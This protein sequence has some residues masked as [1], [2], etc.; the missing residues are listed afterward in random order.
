MNKDRQPVV[1]LAPDKFKG[2]LDAFDVCDALAGGLLDVLPGAHVIRRP[3][4]DGG[5]GSLKVLARPGMQMISITVYDPLMRPIQAVYGMD[6]TRAF[7]EMSAAAGL[8]L[9]APEERNPLQTTT[10]GVGQMIADALHRGARDIYIMAGGSA[11][12]DAGMGMAA[13][14]GY[15]FTDSGARELPP[16]GAS[17]NKVHA[18]VPPEVKPWEKGRFFILADVRN[19]LY[20]PRGAAFEYAAQKGAD[21][22]AMQILDAG[23]RHWAAVVKDQLQTDVSTLSGGGAAG[24]LGAGAVAFL[25]ASIVSGARMIAALLGVEPLVARTD[26]LVSGE[27]RV[28]RQT[29]E[30]KVVSE[31]ARLARLHHKP[32]ALVCGQLE[33]DADTCRDVLDARLCLSLVNGQVS[34]ERALKQ[35]RALLVEKGRILG[36]HI[37]RAR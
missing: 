16:I 9:L 30:G 17:L 33:L 15:R 1:L 13:A 34:R 26:W 27:G 36:Q 35:A 2:S 5:E 18:I 23:L 8:C 25:K 12:N 3:L 31:V 37:I 24:G 11:T 29:L 28:D 6:D 10:F 21:K 7:V 4:A 20:G 32:L 19:P 14:L 22:A